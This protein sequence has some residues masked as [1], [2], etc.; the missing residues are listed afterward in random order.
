MVAAPDTRPQTTGRRLPRQL[1]A[2]GLWLLMINGMI[3]AGIFGVPAAAAA[4]TGA[5]SPFL[6]LLCAL[7]IAP[8][9][10]CF[11]ELASA[12]PDSGGPARY[13][14]IAFGP[15]AGFQAGWALYIARMTA[16]AA[17]INLLVTTLAWF[18]PDLALGTPR[19]A[20]LALLTGLMAWI[21]I[22]G[23]QWAIRA[24]AGLTVLKLVPLVC[25]VLLGLVALGASAAS[26]RTALALWPPAGTDLGA[27]V[28]LAIYVYVGFEAGLIPGG[29]ARRPARDMPRALLLALAASALLYV[30]L[31]WVCL[32]LLPDLSGSPQP[33]VA[34]GERLLGTAGSLLVVATV[35][36]S[37]AAN[38]VGSMFSAPRI[39]FAL[40]EQGCLPAA[41]AHVH[42]RHTTPSTSIL[43][44]AALCWALAASGSFV[45]LAG[46]SVLV[47]VLL[48][49]ACTLSVSRV[50]AQAPADAWRLPLGPVLPMCSAL[51][52]LW[53]LSQVSWTSVAAAAALLVAG[54]GFYLWARRASAR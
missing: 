5:F 30:L 51:A 36:A 35:A 26:D 42:P 25:L 33:V 39:S 18:A 19:L 4:L 13:V 50:R 16:F 28:L 1:T 15:L 11:A 32:A 3:G 22:V 24:L 23:V 2:L 53:L 10:L 45:W 43:W 9:L 27:A 52:C 8:I 20:A 38:L 46:L 34:L 31:Q 37:V 54:S 44:Y 48:Y 40:A 21:N 41:F 12:T 49:L 47:R 14:G 29:E 7:L 6:F 17:N